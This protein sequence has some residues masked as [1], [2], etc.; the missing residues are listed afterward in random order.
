MESEKKT[1]LIIEDNEI[2]MFLFQEILELEGHYNL[3]SACTGKD[4]IKLLME[5][6]PELLILDI[7]LPDVGPLEIRDLVKDTPELAKTKILAITASLTQKQKVGF[8]NEFVH[9]MKKP[10]DIKEFAE[11][12]KELLNEREEAKE[13]RG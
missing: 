1:I 2:N 12:V 13:A 8:G 3:L 9:F 11:K 4:G 6:K 10:I 5:H 7:A